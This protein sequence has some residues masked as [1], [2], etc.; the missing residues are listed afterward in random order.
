MLVS[1]TVLTFQDANG[2]N[3]ALL[4][5]Y[6]RAHGTLHL[7]D[8]A[9]AADRGEASIQLVEGRAYEYNLAPVI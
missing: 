9:E 8:D 7:L 3:I 2:Q 5:I 1:E 4:T 6:E